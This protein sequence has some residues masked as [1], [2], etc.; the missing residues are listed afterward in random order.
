M[1]CFCQQGG[2]GGTSLSSD[3]TIVSV[4]VK[5]RCLIRPKCARRLGKEAVQEKL[6][7]LTVPFAAGQLSHPETLVCPHCYERARARACTHKPHR[8][9]LYVSQY[10]LACWRVTHFCYALLLF[11]RLSVRCVRARRLWFIILSWEQR[12]MR[13]KMLSRGM[14]W[15]GIESFSYFAY[16]KHT[17]Q[18]PL[19]RTGICSSALFIH[20]D[21]QIIKNFYALCFNAR[22][23]FWERGRFHC[24]LDIF[25]VC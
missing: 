12:H 11:V 23:V 15:M 24:L 18:I 20:P 22:V 7:T 16:H 6:V 14:Q 8:C 4:T 19:I 9:L 13:L 21:K 10:R 17:S 25:D 5:K 3:V 1:H 2:G